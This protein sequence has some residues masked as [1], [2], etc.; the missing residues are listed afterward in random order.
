MTRLGQTRVVHWGGTNEPENDAHD[1]PPDDPPPDPSNYN[2]DRTNQNDNRNRQN[3][4]TVYT[5]RMITV[6]NGSNPRV[7]YGTPPPQHMGR[8]AGRC[9]VV[10][11]GVQPNF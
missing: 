3:C 8:P 5:V 7:G 1:P 10:N 6:K 9:L 4:L 2:N 11:N